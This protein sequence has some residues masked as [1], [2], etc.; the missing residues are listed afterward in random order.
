MKLAIVKPFIF[1]LLLIYHHS[2]VN[3]PEELLLCSL[4]T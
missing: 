4:L 2:Q 3:L 1:K